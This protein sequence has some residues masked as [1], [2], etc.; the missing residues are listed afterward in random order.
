MIK[1]MFSVGIL[2]FLSTATF[3]SEPFDTTNIRTNDVNT[4][5]EVLRQKM[6][7]SWEEYGARTSHCLEA[8]K[9]TEAPV[10]NL[11]KLEEL[12][13]EKKEFLYSI[14]YLSRVN[15]SK[16]VALEQGTFLIDYSRFQYFLKQNDIDIPTKAFKSDADGESAEI[17][18]NRDFFDAIDA[19]LFPLGGEYIHYAPEI[20][21]LHL[22]AQQKDY[23]E[24]TVGK[25][26][27]RA[28]DVSRVLYPKE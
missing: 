15:Y 3:A 9:Q 5:A 17:A 18:D 24:Q 27:F 6:A 22:T 12:Q 7:R 20:T 13:F 16:C 19:I 11:K 25:K 4:V 28:V 26:M 14:E 21:Y 8:I 10:F 1:Q 23:L 2:L